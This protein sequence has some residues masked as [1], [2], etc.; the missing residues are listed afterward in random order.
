MP[1]ITPY[2][3]A[4]KAT[5]KRLTT[6]TARPRTKKSAARTATTAKGRVML[7]RIQN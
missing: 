1:T 2:G 3:S 4:R 5:A 7:V 6:T